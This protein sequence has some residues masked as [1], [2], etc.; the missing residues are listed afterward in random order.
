MFN[1][2]HSNHNCKLCIKF[3]LSHSFVGCCTNRNYEAIVSSHISITICA[4]SYCIYLITCKKIVT[5]S[6]LEK[7]A[8]H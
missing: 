5:F 2:G 1:K 7:Q 3:K 6:I 8:K 4:I